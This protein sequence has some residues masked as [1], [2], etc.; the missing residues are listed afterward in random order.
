MWVLIALFYAETSDIPIEMKVYD[1][2]I[3]ESEVECFDSMMYNR[4]GLVKSLSE[5]EIS[6]KYSVKC[7][8]AN[9]Y[10]EVKQALRV[11]QS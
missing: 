8:D 5:L 9:K 1:A 10:I 2:V 4:E 11:E 7:V 3:F 6:N